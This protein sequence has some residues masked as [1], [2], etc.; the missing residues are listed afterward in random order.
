MSGV[1][2]VVKGGP[3]VFPNGTNTFQTSSNL[4]TIDAS[5]STS[6]NAGALTYSWAAMPVGSAGIYFGNTATPV[7][8]F[9]NKGNYTITVTVTDAKGA[10]ATQTITIQ[11]V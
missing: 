1:T 8:Q 4:V 6:T 5:Q 10:T 3:G 2:I 9:F 7:I 11:Y